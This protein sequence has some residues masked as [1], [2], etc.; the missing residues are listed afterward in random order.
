MQ[1]TVDAPGQLLRPSEALKRF[2]PPQAGSTLPAQAA[3]R[4]RFGFRVGEF[5]L[6]IGSDTASE[7]VAPEAIYAIPNTPSWWL[8][9]M[10]LRGNL[11]PIFDLHRVLETGANDAGKR[12]VLLLDEGE[13]MVGIPI[14]GLPRSLELSRRLTN[15]PPLPAI[16]KGYISET[17]TE[18][19]AVWLEFDHQGFCTALGRRVH[20]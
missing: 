3:K 15:T 10:N 14:D 9:L 6:L 18:G 11:V 16:L 19:G 5:G 17:Y 20:A 7:V 1:D 13:A 4:V 12:M 8:G 2:D